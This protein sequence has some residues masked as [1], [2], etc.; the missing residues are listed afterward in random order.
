MIAGHAQQGGAE[1]HR[2]GAVGPAGRLAAT[3]AALTALAWLGRFVQDDAFIS[4]RYAR[5][6]V[7][8][9]GLV[10]NPGEYVEGYTNFLWTLWMALPLA[11]GWDPVR[12]SQITGM[13]LFAGSLLATHRLARALGFS[14]A[15]AWLAVVLLGTNYSFSR[16]ATGGLETQLQALLWVGPAAL[17][18]AGLGRVR[19]GLTRALVVSVAAAAAMMTRLDSILFAALVVGVG[20]ASVATQRAPA[21][22][23][24]R[25]LAILIAPAA[26][27]VGAWLVWKQSYYGGVLPNTYWAKLASSRVTLRGAYYVGIFLVGY[28]LLP[29]ALIYVARLGR[30]WKRIGGV[31]WL[32]LNGPLVLWLL[33]VVA[34]GGDFMEFRFLVPAMP[35]GFLALAWTICESGPGRRGRAAWIACVLAGSLLHALSFDASPLKRGLESIGELHGHVAGGTAN[36]VEVGRALGRRF[37]EQDGVLIAVAAA[38]AIP[39]HSRLQAVDMLGLNDPRVAREGAFL[40]DR[41]GH[42][43]IATIAYLRERGVH[44]LIGHPMLVPT[45]PPLPRQL[46]TTALETMF[47]AGPVPDPESLLDDAGLVLI[48]VSPEWTLAAL[49]LTPHPRVEAMLTAGELAFVSL[50]A[51]ELPALQDSGAP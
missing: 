15:T 51:P 30:L 14:A 40:S 24:A 29:L 26:L 46:S 5:H 47:V 16:Y 36:W 7:E 6:L 39:Y 19:F 23:R 27:L 18:A 12:F 34:V 9:R 28:L 48:P 43:R 44:L 42:H 10:W 2:V 50:R 25:G 35:V 38:G 20:A 45:A 21:T 32:L 33:Y 3:V 31:P 37:R 49:Y 13:V 17:V 11:L 4:F 22:E 8:G 41:A 1:G